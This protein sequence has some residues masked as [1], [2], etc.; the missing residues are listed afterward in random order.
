MNAEDRTKTK[1]TASTN[2]F[3]SGTLA[4]DI[5]EQGQHIRFGDSDTGKS[6]HDGLPRKHQ[7]KPLFDTMKRK[8]FFW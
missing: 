6:G 7:S 8:P 2:V 4:F 3:Q 1:K 5:V